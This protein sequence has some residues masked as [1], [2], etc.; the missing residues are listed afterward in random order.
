MVHT[1]AHG[2]AG[3]AQMPDL[4]EEMTDYLFHHIFLPPKLPGGYD[5]HRNE[6]QHL[7]ELV[8]DSLK[9]FLEQA[10]ADHTTAIQVAI[11]MIEN[12]KTARDVHGV[13]Q[14]VGTQTV[15]QRLC[16]PEA[17]AAFHI[18]A[19]NAGVI[20]RKT[21]ESVMI[22]VFEL[23]PTNVSVNSTLGRLVRQ[24]PAIA[25]AVQSDRFNDK[26]FQSVLTKTLVKMSRQSEQEMKAKA[27][28]ANQD[29]EE[30][31][32]TINPRVVTELLTGFL[33]GLGEQ[34]DV[35]GVCKNT[36]EEV[37][38]DQ[39]LLPW[40]RS[41]MWL[42]IRVSLQ[43]IMSRVAADSGETYKTFMPFFMSR[44]LEASYKRTP[45]NILHSMRTKIS[46][47][48][49]KLDQP[50]N[51]LWLGTIHRILSHTAGG[52]D[53]QWQQLRESLEL[54]LDL[55]ALSKL[56]MHKDV[57]FHLPKLDEFISSV[58]QPDKIN[59][60]ARASPTSQIQAFDADSLPRISKSTD[61]YRPFHLAT[62]ESWV[63]M[64]LDSWIAKHI[65]D[66]R[67]CLELST[68]IRNYH[69]LGSPWYERR[70]EGVSRMHLVIL[71]L[72]VAADKAALASLPML[73][74]YEPEVPVEVYQA[75]LLGHREAMERLC[76]AE[77]YLSERTAFA[78]TQKRPSVFTSF[79][80]G[81]SL[82]VRYFSES[83]E[84]Q[85]LK[86]DIEQHASEMRIAK[87]LEFAK[88][89]SEYKRLM[90]LYEKT[91]CSTMEWVEHGLTHSKH[92]PYC[93]RCVYQTKATTLS[94]LIH[95]WPLPDD[96][97]A[98]QATV[99]ELKLPFAFGVWRDL[100]IYLIND[101]LK[102]GSTSDS[103]YFHYRLK[104]YVGLCRGQAT[105]GHSSEE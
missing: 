51:G 98:A 1:V 33:L 17:S 83:L 97:L 54:P 46:R 72:W 92:H 69:A 37:T 52:L 25:I 70:P 15:L 81:Q 40:R 94:I 41:P 59:R 84:H 21:T 93:P 99:F 53:R 24:F 20:I 77:K 103:P 35:P 86:R 74:D 30:D 63:A 78:K 12:L 89:K 42:L 27:R 6:E 22:E 36:R 105:R 58:V 76:R 56:E 10:H 34:V 45:G 31:R 55:T 95:E 90:E 29:H 61:E 80:H 68:L 18:K 82:P 85:N 57:Y 2:D 3:S 101:V 73:R 79:G 26:E 75:L 14:E 102:C 5:C 60:L 4:G 91:A 11:G 16:L 50:K 87:V 67:A 96:T 8:L 43:L 49:L 32:D 9:S 28:K 13:L 71:E 62:V 88:G 64:N 44:I 65:H 7:V 104:T 19:Q 48:L 66:E 47:R 23:S 38:W 100:T 39:S